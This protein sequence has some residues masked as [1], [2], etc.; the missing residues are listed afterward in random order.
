MRTAARASGT[1]IEPVAQPGGALGLL[2]GGTQRWVSQ[3]NLRHLTDDHD[4]EVVSF[5]VEDDYGW[6]LRLQPPQG[7]ADWLYLEEF[8]I[9][10]V[11]R[12]AK[13]RGRKT[14]GPRS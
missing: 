11:R 4:P 1:A 13:R 6:V 7:F 9:P 5:V 3:V 2:A 14:G 12:L 8:R 10:L